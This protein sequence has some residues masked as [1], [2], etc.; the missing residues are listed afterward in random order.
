MCVKCE[1]F[2]LFLAVFYCFLFF[3]IRASSIFFCSVLLSFVLYFFRFHSRTNLWGGLRKLH[4]GIRHTMRQWLVIGFLCFILLHIP[5]WWDSCSWH[6]AETYNYVEQFRE[7]GLD[8]T[9]FEQAWSVI[10]QKSN[11]RVTRDHVPPKT[12]WPVTRDHVQP[13]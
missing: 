6:L 10:F 11:S 4:T 12:A 7:Q 3:F 13:C 1:F 8:V 2:C 5:W 9:D